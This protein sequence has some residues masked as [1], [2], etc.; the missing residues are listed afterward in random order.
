MPDMNEPD[1]IVRG[2]GVGPMHVRVPHQREYSINALRDKRLGE[3]FMAGNFIEG[4]FIS[5]ARRMLPK[6]GRDRK[7]GLSFGS[8]QAI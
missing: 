3:N 8:P 1:A 6:S 5:T 7:A 4:L 2:H